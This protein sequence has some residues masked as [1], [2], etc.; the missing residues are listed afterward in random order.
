MKTRRVISIAAALLL[1][2]PAVQAQLKNF[3]VSA[4]AGMIRTLWTQMGETS[5][6]L[7]AFY[8][9]IRIGGIFFVPYLSWG[10]SWGYWSDGIEKALPV[11]DM[12]TYSQ[13]SHVAAVRIG[14]HP[15]ILDSRVPIPISVFA[16]A[17]E[18]FVTYEYIGGTSLTGE[19][20]RNSADQS[21]SVFFGA[22]FSF[23]VLSIMKL[24]AEAQQFIP[25][26]SGEMN[27][28]YKNRRV[29]TIGFSVS[30]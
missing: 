16:G 17:A 27:Q 12:A 28:A 25:F 1:V 9:E 11:M 15:R 26:G 10:V 14:F 20:G 6:P 3:S 21:F 18:H 30:F 13:S 5:V 7:W 22:G 4:R 8:P 2:S 19:G 29:V 24:E 23:P